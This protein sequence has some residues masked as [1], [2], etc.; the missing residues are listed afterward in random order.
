MRDGI[1]IEVEAH[2]GGLAGLHRHAF[3]ERIG[4]VRQHQQLWRFLGEG[5]A[6]AEG[7]LSGTAPVRRQAAAP[8]LG[9]DIE[10]VEIGELS[11]RE[12]VVAHIADGA[13][14]ATLL[15]AACHRH[16]TRLKAI[17]TG[18][19]D[20]GGME[21]NGVAL[22]LQHC[23]LEIVVEQDT[24]TSVPGREGADV[25]AQEVLHLGVEEEAQKNLARVA[26]HHDEGQQGTTR[27]ADHEMTKMPPVDL[28]LLAGQAAQT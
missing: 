6:D 27:A 26:Q 28:P 18:E 22:A 20:Q 11:R 16:R 2:I 14:D 21:A 1:I 13:L 15:V 17:V 12:E 9:L 23:A 7:V 19:R 8:G 3:D 4:V 25:T 5:L 24:R 10:V